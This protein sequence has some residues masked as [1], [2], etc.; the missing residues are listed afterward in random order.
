MSER[1]T[2]LTASHWGVGLATIEGGRVVSVAGHPADPAASEINANIPGSLHGRARVRR[3][4]VRKSWLAGRPGAVPRGQDSFVEVS[5]ERALDLIAAE[6][7]RV[8]AAHGNR[9]IFAGSYGWSSAGRFQDQSWL[10]HVD[11]T[12]C[13]HFVSVEKEERPFH[14][15]TAV[16]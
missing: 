5:W 11:C 7:T 8:R 14:T 16:S 15:Q 6:L 12:E 2:K 3:P 9:G 10:Q 13:E 4:A 1:Q